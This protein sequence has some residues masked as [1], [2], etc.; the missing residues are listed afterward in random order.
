MAKGGSGPGAVGGASQSPSSAFGGRPGGGSTGTR[1]GGGGMTGAGREQMS[2]FNSNTY[3]DANGMTRN[4]TTGAMVYGNN[5]KQ[6]STPT[7]SASIQSRV[8][9]GGL[10]K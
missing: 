10:G 3:V 7:K 8:G 1:P 4:R 6:T 5:Q 9:S 2:G